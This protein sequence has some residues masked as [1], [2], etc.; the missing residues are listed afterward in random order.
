MMRNY[1]KHTIDISSSYEERELGEFDTPRTTEGN[2]ETM[3]LD[4]HN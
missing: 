4:D 1:K 3:F 2:A